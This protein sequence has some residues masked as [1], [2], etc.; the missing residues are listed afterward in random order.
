MAQGDPAVI[1]HHPSEKFRG[2]VLRDHWRLIYVGTDTA[3]LSTTLFVTKA[4]LETATTGALAIADLRKAGATTN[5]NGYI[6]MGSADEILLA[7]GGTGAENSTI[8][9]QIEA[10]REARDALGSASLCYVTQLL[11]D[12]V[13]TLGTGTAGAAGA[14][15]TGIASTDKLADGITDTISDP[16]IDLYSPADNTVG[17]LRLKAH[18]APILRLKIDLGTATKAWAIMAKLQGDAQNTG[19]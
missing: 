5:A 12:G 15:L 4:T 14:A 9:Y 11:A 16:G 18:N 6:R 7:F 3:A 19:N 8:N 10:L 1:D 13:L 2:P 17:F